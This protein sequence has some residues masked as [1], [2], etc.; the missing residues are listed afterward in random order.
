MKKIIDVFFED[1]N[2]VEI[3]LKYNINIF[4]VVSTGFFGQVEV[5]AIK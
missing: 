4:G 5:S 1:T 2:I 3:I